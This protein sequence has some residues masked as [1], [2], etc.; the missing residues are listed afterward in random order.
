MALH[1]DEIRNR[2]GTGPVTLHKQSAAK[3][4]GNSAPNGLG[5]YAS[6][7][8][9]SLVDVN[10][11]VQGWNLASAMSSAYYSPQACPMGYG[12]SI[13]NVGKTASRFDT[14]ALD[15]NNGAFDYEQHVT[16]HGDLA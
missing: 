1:V 4:W 16:A 6:L 8:V 10:T 12:G 2:A 14:W 9:S 5:V 11:G 13:R 15:S 7:N 3:M